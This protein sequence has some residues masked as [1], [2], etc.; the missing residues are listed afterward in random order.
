LC[1]SPCLDIPTKSKFYVRNLVTKH[2]NDLQQKSDL[3][4]NWAHDKFVNWLMVK[5]HIGNL[6]YLNNINL[7]IEF[8]N[9]SLGTKLSH[10]S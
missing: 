3:Q 2:N 1:L 5:F 9:S 6:V 4:N 8:T 7:T 10:L